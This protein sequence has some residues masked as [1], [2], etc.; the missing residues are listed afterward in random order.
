MAAV[1]C[2]ALGDRD[3][4]VSVVVDITNPPGD[5]HVFVKVAT[6]RTRERSRNAALWTGKNQEVCSYDCVSTSMKEFDVWHLAVADKSFL[7]QVVC[8]EADT[9]FVKKSTASGMRWSVEVSRSRRM[10]APRRR[11]VCFRD[12]AETVGV[13]RKEDVARW[14]TEQPECVDRGSLQHQ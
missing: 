14:S 11:V 9:G 6:C 8:P 10:W 3:V 1:D 5:D 2:R 7:L 12:H 13:V 4:G